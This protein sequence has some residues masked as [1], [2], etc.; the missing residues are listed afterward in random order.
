[1][2]EK[3]ILF[4]A[5]PCCVLLRTA[6]GVRAEINY[7]LKLN[8]VNNLNFINLIHSSAVVRSDDD[9]LENRIANLSSGQIELKAAEGENLRKI[10]SLYE[11]KVNESVSDL[12]NTM[13]SPRPIGREAAVRSST[14]HTNG[15]RSAS[16][17]SYAGARSRGGHCDKL[18]IPERVKVDKSVSTEAEVLEVPLL[19]EVKK[20][21]D[22]EDVISDIYE[23]NTSQSS[24]GGFFLFIKNSIIKN[25]F[26]TFILPLSIPIIS[27]LI[28]NYGIPLF[29]YVCP[30]CFNYLA[31]L[32]IKFGILFFIY[33]LFIWF[34]LLIL[35]HTLRLY[36]YYWFIVR[37]S[38]QSLPQPAS[39]RIAH[40]RG[41][42]AMPQRP[43]GEGCEAGAS[44]D[45]IKEKIEAQNTLI[46]EL[47]PGYITK[48]ILK[49]INEYKDS[50]ETSE[51]IGVNVELRSD[52][53]LIFILLILIFIIYFTFL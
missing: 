49:I 42:A 34:I 12:K 17:T 48:Q 13:P 8:A 31:S 27:Y 41:A 51:K 50:E 40:S 6:R 36:I 46:L 38:A 47:L 33:P 7:Y 39:L 52:L 28:I 45:N 2:M 44:K 18:P 23:L 1:M 16:H 21:G 4:K 15:V 10:A 22:S 32:Y 37:Q 19:Q 24:T 20:V 5:L 14:Q 29:K 25:N 26:S 11:V 35:Y 53:L 3:T 30:T 9:K 43:N